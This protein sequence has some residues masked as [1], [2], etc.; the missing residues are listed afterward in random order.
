MGWMSGDADWVHPSQR[1][2]EGKAALE[3]EEVRQVG[4]D[5]AQGISQTIKGYYDDPGAEPM[6][7][8]FPPLDVGAR[9][10]GVWH[11]EKQ[12]WFKMGGE[13]F[14]TQ[15]KALAEAQCEMTNRFGARHPDELYKV[16]CIEEW[17]DEQ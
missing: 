10:Y 9:H 14:A 13:V 5:V 6:K 15:H 1:T 3:E 2:P 11:P 4:D 16:R 8:D 12:W 7:F 17:A